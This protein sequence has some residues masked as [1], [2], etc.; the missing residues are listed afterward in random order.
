MGERAEDATRLGISLMPGRCHVIPNRED[1]E[2]RKELGRYR[3]M[4]KIDFIKME[5]AE[6]GHD[7]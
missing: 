6:P 2:K 5:Q 4:S 3:A 1:V 7:R